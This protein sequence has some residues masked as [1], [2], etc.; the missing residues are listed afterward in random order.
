DDH[1][2]KCAR[3]VRGEH[4]IF[5]LLAVSPFAGMGLARVG[6]GDAHRA[7]DAVPVD[8]R[9]EHEAAHAHHARRF[10]GGAHQLW[11]QVM[12]GVRESD[13][14]EDGVDAARGS[15]CGARVGEIGGEYLSA[16]EGA[17]H[18]LARA[19]DYA[20]RDAAPFELWCD[21]LSDGPCCAEDGGFFY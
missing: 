6:L 9:R 17:F 12:R 5:L 18:F 16:G 8:A 1:G 21:R 13:A 19:A 10:D 20:Q 3:R 14:I 2:L 11:M 4:E 15:A 7:W